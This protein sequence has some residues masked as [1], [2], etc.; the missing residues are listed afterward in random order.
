[1]SG[2]PAGWSATT[3]LAGEPF[4]YDPTKK[5]V[6][7]I[8]DP[9]L[10]ELFDM[11]AP[12]YLFNTTEKANVY[13]VAKNETPILV[14]KDLFVRSQLTFAEV[15]SMALRADV[16]IIP[17]LSIRTNQQDSSLIAWIRNHYTP[18]TRMLAICDGASTAAATGLYDGKPITCHASDFAGI[19][20]QFSRPQWTQNVSVTKSGN[21]FSTAGVSNAVEGSL[22]VID[23]LFGTA[24]M[25]QVMD[26]V[27]YRYSQVRYEHQSVAVNGSAKMTALKKIFFRRNKNLGILMQNGLNE[28][29][30]AS[31]LDTYARTF[32]SSVT[33]FIRND[34]TVKTKFGLSLIFTGKADTKKIDELHVLVPG[35][36]TAVEEAGF[37]GADIVTYGEFASG[38]PIDVCLKR[39]SS[40]YGRSFENLVKVSLDYN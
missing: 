11:L 24:T 16:I 5:N 22:A 13:I 1:M 3:S 20:S 39:I 35:A 6:L 26:N 27:N 34:S 4:R 14:K 12:Y 33:T 32:P 8:A 15:D 2:I 25:E 28:F 31:V 36:L 10:T 38:Y 7:I 29:E 9:K 17:A 18:S 30:F 37:K 40:Q 23:E 21:L 19:K